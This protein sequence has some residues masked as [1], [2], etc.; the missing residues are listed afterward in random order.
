M[1]I[2]EEHYAYAHYSTACG[3]TENATHVRVL[4]NLEMQKNTLN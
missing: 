4:W 3:N 1:T 2:E